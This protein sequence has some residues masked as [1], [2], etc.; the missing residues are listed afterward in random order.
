MLSYILALIFLDDLFTYIA[1]AI[2]GYNVTAIYIRLLVVYL[3]H[4]LPQLRCEPGGSS[5]SEAHFTE[6]V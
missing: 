2:C 5:S 1:I 3:I 6:S 4:Q